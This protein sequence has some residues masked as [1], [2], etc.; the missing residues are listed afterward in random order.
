MA[1]LQQLSAI[2]V[3]MVQMSLQARKLIDMV[4]RSETNVLNHGGLVSEKPGHHGG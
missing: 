4:N 3:K 2:S 1:I